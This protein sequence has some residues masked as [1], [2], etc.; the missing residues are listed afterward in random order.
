MFHDNQGAVMADSHEKVAAL[1]RLAQLVQELEAAEGALAQWQDRD[2]NRRDGSTRQDNMHE[3]IGRAS[4]DR[5]W[6]ARNAVDAQ[7]KLIASFP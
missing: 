4:R 3:E 2:L 1:A 7:Q 6:S 5:V